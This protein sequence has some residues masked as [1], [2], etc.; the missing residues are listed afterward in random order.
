MGT[1]TE[2]SPEELVGEKEAQEYFQKQTTQAIVQMFNA[3][4]FRFN[5][6]QVSNAFIYCGRLA[7]FLNE[8]KIH[9]D[10]DELFFKTSLGCSVG[11]LELLVFRGLGSGQAFGKNYNYGWHAKKFTLIEAINEIEKLRHYIYDKF[12]YLCS[13]HEIVASIPMPDFG[14]EKGIESGFEV[15]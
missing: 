3:N 6:K 7:K 12:A 1:I 4:F 13:R 10:I 2:K 14:S 5:V 8:E 9:K 15:K 11:G